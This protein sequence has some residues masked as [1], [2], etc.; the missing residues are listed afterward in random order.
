MQKLK[1]YC[2]RRQSSRES[3][4]S[5]SYTKISDKQLQR[6]ERRIYRHLITPRLSTSLSGKP[7]TRPL[8]RSRR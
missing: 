2:K 3:L 5:H 8:K 4:G 7:F 6:R 1:S